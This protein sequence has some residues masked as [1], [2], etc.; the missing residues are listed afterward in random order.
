MDLPFLWADLEPRQI[1][2]NC[3][4]CHTPKI[5]FIGLGTYPQY[6]NVT[7]RQTHNL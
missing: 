4:Q 7:H 1:Q 3:P 2:S 6:T 5:N